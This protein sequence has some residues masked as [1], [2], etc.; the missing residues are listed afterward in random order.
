MVPFFWKRISNQNEFSITGIYAFSLW[1]IEEP[2]DKPQGSSLE[3]K[4]IVLAGAGKPRR[5]VVI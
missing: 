1:K 5:N 2:H 3:R 4:F